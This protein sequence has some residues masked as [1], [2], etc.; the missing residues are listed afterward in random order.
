MIE[1]YLKQHGL[2]YLRDSDGDFQVQFAY[3]EDVGGELTIYCGAEGRD[4]DIYVVRI[5]SSRMVPK[6]EW[7][8]AITL[9]NTWN[10][11]KRWPKAYLRVKDPST[12]V[13]GGIFLEE[14]L[15]LE[16]GVHFELLDSYTTTA[17]AAANE[18]WRWLHSDFGL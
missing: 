13:V 10:K 2:R 3:D 15:N 6:A 7:G 11:D 12:D 16:A 5:S 18:F 8:R 9:C 1:R 17:I 14:E 4:H